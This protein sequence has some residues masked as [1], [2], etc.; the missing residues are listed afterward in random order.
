MTTAC[1][2]TPSPGENQCIPEIEEAIEKVRANPC[3]KR[4]YDALSGLY[5]AALAWEERVAFM[6][7]MIEREP[8]LPWPHYCRGGA[9]HSLNKLHEAIDDYSRAIEL[10]PA[11]GDA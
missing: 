9:Y 8:N 6:T 3:D 11:Y 5:S 1:I 10:N 7:E 2:P 4:A